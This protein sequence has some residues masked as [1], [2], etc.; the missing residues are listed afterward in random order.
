[1]IHRGSNIGFLFFEK[2]AQGKK[3]PENSFTGTPV[4]EHQGE[5]PGQKRLYP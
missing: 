5:M 3:R 2:D 4:L 1:V